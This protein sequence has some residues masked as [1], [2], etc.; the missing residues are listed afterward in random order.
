MK[1]MQFILPNV[2]GQKMKFSFTSAQDDDH[3][4]MIINKYLTYDMMIWW[5]IMYKLGTGDR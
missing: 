1:A 4:C 2:S 5:S 3:R